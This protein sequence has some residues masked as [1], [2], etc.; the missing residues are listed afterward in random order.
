MLQ[1]MSGEDVL[2]RPDNDRMLVTAAAA[3]SRVLSDSNSAF[4]FSSQRNWLTSHR[5]LAPFHRHRCSSESGFDKG[6]FG[7]SVTAHY[8]SCTELDGCVRTVQSAATASTFHRPAYRL[9]RHLTTINPLQRK[10]IFYGGSVVSLR[11]STVP[12]GLHSRPN[13]HLAGVEVLEPVEEPSV[14]AGQTRTRSRC[15][16]RCSTLLVMLDV[17]LF[18]NCAFLVICSASAFIQLGY[19]VPI[20]FLTPYT[21]TLQLTTSDA[22]VFLSVIGKRLSSFY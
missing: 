15:G 7:W 1:E 2:E 12:G 9:R 18:R 10:D 21:Q 22:A 16:E 17:S 19:F 13:V 3:S 11:S 14:A 8:R 4:G 20:V 6:R 5:P